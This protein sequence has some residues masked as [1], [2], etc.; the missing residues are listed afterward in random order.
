MTFP[1]YYISSV[2]VSV[3]RATDALIDKTSRLDT[4][5]VLRSNLINPIGSNGEPTSLNTPPHLE[6]LRERVRQ[7]L[8]YLET[9]LG[10]YS[11]IGRAKLKAFYEYIMK[12]FI[13]LKEMCPDWMS[14]AFA[15]AIGLMLALIISILLVHASIL[16][17]N[18]RALQLEWELRLLQWKFNQRMKHSIKSRDWELL[19]EMVEN[20]R[21]VDEQRARGGRI[22]PRLAPGSNLRRA[23]DISVEMLKYE[24]LL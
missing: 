9:L 7:A 22:P 21:E 18:R 5:C 8:K 20:L 23:V 2:P 3:I 13:E 24:L 6:S 19:L 17:R 14:S 12:L 16:F 15:V 1:T 11:V 4:P 10:D